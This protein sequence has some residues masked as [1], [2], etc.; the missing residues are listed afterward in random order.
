MPPAELPNFFTSYDLIQ[1]HHVVAVN[2]IATLLN[3]FMMGNG[4]GKA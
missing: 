4:W 2:V 1:L 3:Q